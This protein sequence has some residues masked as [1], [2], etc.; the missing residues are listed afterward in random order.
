MRNQTI[1]SLLCAV[2]A[3]AFLI[4]V[5][6]ADGLFGFGGL[7]PADAWVQRVAT[8]QGL[9][10]ARPWT[11]SGLWQC[12]AQ[13]PSLVWL[14]LGAGIPAG[15]T[16]SMTLV[17]AG[18]LCAACAVG[19]C[20]PYVWCMACIWFAWVSVLNAAGDVF[21]R[22]QWDSLLAETAAWAVLLA[23]WSKDDP[24][25]D[26]G[27]W[28]LRIAFVKVT[29][30][31]GAVKL[32]SGCSAWAS[33]MA[34]AHHHATQPI[35]TPAAWWGNAQ[36]PL[37]HQAAT[38]FA[39]LA[40][41][42]LALTGLVPGA[43][44]G[45]LTFAVAL[46]LQAGIALS[47]NYTYFTALTCVL[48]AACLPQTTGQ[49]C[50]SDRPG[51]MRWVAGW[52]AVVVCTVYVTHAMFQLDHVPLPAAMEA[53][54]SQPGLGS[55]QVD[56]L[57]ATVHSAEMNSAM[58]DLAQ[59]VRLGAS[60]AQLG[61]WW[62]SWSISL[63]TQD[64]QAWMQA[65]TDKAVPWLVAWS[66][67][68]V[69]AS[70][71]AWA[72]KHVMRARKLLVPWALARV[73]V[74][75]VAALVLTCAGLAWP[76]TITS[77]GAI[78][79]PLLDIAVAAP[80]LHLAAGYGVFRTITGIATAHSAAQFAQPMPATWQVPSDVVVPDLHGSTALRR[81][82]LARSTA[83]LSA[84]ARGA[85][86]SVHT[87]HAQGTT[88]AWL[89][90]DAPGRAPNCSRA[91]S[92]SGWNPYLSSCGAAL[93]ST[94]RPEVELEVLL[95][96]SRQWH[97]VRFPAK[98]SGVRQ[99]PKWIAPAHPRLDWQMWF[100]A[101]GSYQHAPWLVALAQHLLQGAGPGIASLLH[102]TT[103]Q[104]IGSA[105]RGAAL[106]PVLAV[107]ANTWHFDFTAP[108]WQ[109]G[110]AL[111]AHTIALPPSMR[112]HNLT[113]HWYCDVQA[114]L[115]VDAT[116]APA[117][118]PATADHCRH[119]AAN[120]TRWWAKTV[121]GEYLPQI[122]VGNPSVEQFLQHH[123]MMPPSAKD[124]RRAAAH[125][126][127]CE[128]T[129]PPTALPSHAYVHLDAGLGWLAPIQALAKF[130][131]LAIP[132]WLS[133]AWRV[134]IPAAVRW[135][136]DISVPHARYVLCYGEQLVRQALL[137]NGLV[138]ALGGLVGWLWALAV[139]HAW[140]AERQCCSVSAQRGEL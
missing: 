18:L 128:F 57:G 20:R 133:R 24:G 100:A 129:S 108:V 75:G 34:T 43:V 127:Q 90:V 84:L 37:L 83:A 15:V 14:G 138:P 96:G 78:P 115:A 121:A 106:R 103:V 35:P 74:T 59:R 2:Y 46:A 110:N 111:A 47:G 70:F 21:L 93:P 76:H 12:F 87:Q 67:A 60:Y 85:P 17:W 30:M 130:A 94:A 102:P 120:D 82:S 39:L 79:Q 139:L 118:R 63:R 28:G 51:S 5:P 32:L 26:A 29:A 101:L 95:P 107:R 45:Q 68:C 80:S 36:P 91:A 140:R 11:W 10:P 23:P 131:G 92:W 88:S 53:E 58:A 41:L 137:W 61:A 89:R 8:S 1:L 66:A 116:A 114:M 99:A 16:I 48:A 31:S 72:Y 22:F 33:L 69:A 54:Q 3:A 109:S 65:W 134:A 125:H 73:A 136:W 49:R 122:D 50:K 4:L 97:T 52:T 113:A 27:R 62:N 71:C 19:L 98:P 40:E 123:G 38:A 56:A 112:L 44:M 55:V 124:I 7:T 105:A 6:Q 64:S 126:A 132:G 42:P 119:I 77:G 104:A 25:C 135:A 86:Q 117:H 9:N 13:S 81:Q